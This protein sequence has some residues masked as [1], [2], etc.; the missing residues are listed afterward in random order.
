MTHAKQGENIAMRIIKLDDD[1][2]EQD[3]RKGFMLCPLHRPLRAVKTI[4]CEF[5]LIELVEERPVLT[6]GYGCV[7]HMHTATEECEI[8]K[9]LEVKRAHTGQVVKK[10]QFAKQDDFLTCMIKLKQSTAV[11]SF[12]HC[13]KL[14]RFTLRDEGVTIGIGKIIELPPAGVV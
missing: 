3:L 11:D 13:E 10:P 2:D 6:N 7:I 8:T 4:K 12:H 1:V 5:R 14:G 9:L